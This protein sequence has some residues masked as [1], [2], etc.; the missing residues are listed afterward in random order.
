M[1]LKE[2]RIER[3]IRGEGKG[4]FRGL[5]SFDNELAMEVALSPEQCEEIFKICADETIE[6]AK[7]VSEE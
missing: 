7:T 5:I 2:L 3:K 1:K 4:Q 6:T